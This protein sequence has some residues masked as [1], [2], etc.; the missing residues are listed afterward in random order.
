MVSHDNT[1][2]T[3]FLDPILALQPAL[4]LI[5]V[6]PN[7]N[8]TSDP[9]IGP[10]LLLPPLRRVSQQRDI[11][12]ERLA[13]RA[14]RGEDDERLRRVLHDRDKVVRRELCD[15]RELVAHQPRLD[16]GLGRDARRGRVRREVPDGVA[17]A[18]PDR[19]EDAGV[20]VGGQAEARAEARVGRRVD[21]WG[22]EED[23]G[24]FLDELEGGHVG[25][26]VYE[27]VEHVFCINLGLQV[28]CGDRDDPRCNRLLDE[29][30]HGLDGFLPCIVHL[31]AVMIAA[32]VCQH[33]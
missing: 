26:L 15:A 3:G 22:A 32:R 31:L 30:G 14:E 10:L 5:R 16:G 1:R 7:K 20:Q 8:G 4:P 2:H 23:L 13:R 27:E 6:H 9:L 33:Q 18:L 25:L 29:C 12:L 28:F 21:A 11:A 24:G 17:L 19:D